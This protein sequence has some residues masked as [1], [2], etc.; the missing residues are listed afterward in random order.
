MA[1]IRESRPAAEEA[2]RYVIP[3]GGRPVSRIYLDGRFGLCFYSGGP[4]TEISIGS[5]M[6]FV[7]QEQSSIA[8]PQEPATLVPVLRLF[9]RRVTSAYAFKDG[10]LRVEFQDGSRLEVDPGEKFEP[11]E[12]SAQD[13][14]KIVSTPGGGIAFW[15]S[16]P[17]QT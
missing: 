7:E 2:D 3:I 11:W 14:L 17:A 8:D 16:L 5:R 13:G 4:T 10:S 1:R 15:Q 9:G 12:V 6:R